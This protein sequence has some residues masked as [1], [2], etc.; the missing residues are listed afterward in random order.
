MRTK[1]FLEIIGGTKVIE[2]GGRDYTLIVEV[3]NPSV[4]DRAEMWGLDSFNSKASAN[5]NNDQIALDESV[6]MGKE[7]NNVLN[8]WTVNN[9]Y[10]RYNGKT[11]E[12]S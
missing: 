6:I 4:T 5:I 7:I 9:K 10:H 11:L 12:G 3:Y 8:I 2:G 1:L